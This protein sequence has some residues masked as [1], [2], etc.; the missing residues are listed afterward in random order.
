MVPRHVCVPKAE[1]LRISWGGGVS[2][3]RLT[4]S[5]N[6]SD[7]RKWG[8]LRVCVGVKSIQINPECAAAARVMAG[9]RRL[10][11]VRRHSSKKH[12]LAHG[13]SSSNGF[14]CVDLVPQ[15]SPSPFPI[16]THHE[17]SV[18]VVKVSV[19]DCCLVHFQLGKGQHLAGVLGFDG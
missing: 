11:G 9:I 15:P 2:E 1:N 17:T 6:T 10:H 14:C 3:K 18:Y 4:I 13:T 19:F 8:E 12:A 16:Y 5:A 7:D